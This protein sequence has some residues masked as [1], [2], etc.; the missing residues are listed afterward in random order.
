MLATLFKDERCSQLSTYPMLEKMYLDQ[1]IRKKDLNEFAAVLQ[2]H[3]KAITADGELLNNNLFA[4]IFHSFTDLTKG[5]PLICMPLKTCICSL[6]SV[7]HNILCRF[8]MTNLWAFGL[9]FRPSLI[10]FPS[11]QNNKGE[12]PPVNTIPSFIIAFNCL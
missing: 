6:C 11:Q 10:V 9:G 2:D 12:N 3:Q 4:R 5:A 7:F 8:Q 1:I